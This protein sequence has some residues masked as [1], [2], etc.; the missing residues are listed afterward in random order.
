MYWDRGT[1][2]SASL[3]LA[4]TH[5]LCL[6][7]SLSPAQPRGADVS[8][9]S[10]HSCSAHPGHRYR[11]G[12][13]AAGARA[14]TTNATTA[15]VVRIIFSGGRCIIYNSGSCS[16][17]S[18]SIDP[19]LT[20]RSRSARFHPRHG[21]GPAAYSIPIPSHDR[22][23]GRS[24]QSSQGGRSRRFIRGQGGQS[25]Q[26]SRSRLTERRC[27]LLTATVCFGAAAAAPD[28]PRSWR[29]GL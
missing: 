5:P 4:L 16:R 2:T 22:S 10:P 3:F 13:S 18:I 12:I 8:R 11:F 7:R 15:I 29:L 27:C 23:S 17:A 28:V 25:S 14:G 1:K 24:S 26:G 19:S 9:N 6:H 21:S 20:R